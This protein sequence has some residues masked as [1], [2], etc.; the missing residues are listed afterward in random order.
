MSEADFK[1]LSEAFD[2]LRREC[3]TPEKAMAQLQSEGL[4]DAEGRTAP[5]YRDP[6]EDVAWQ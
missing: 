6:I 1:M 3:D 2:R 4:L 5:M